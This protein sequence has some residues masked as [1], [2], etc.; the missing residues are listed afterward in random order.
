MLESKSC[1]PTLD[2]GC[3]LGSIHV[4]LKSVI[5]QDSHLQDFELYSA[6]INRGLLILHIHNTH[7]RKM[8]L[9]CSV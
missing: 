1:S 8:Q 9:K 7:C 2:E 4:A 3:V 5:L 6:Q